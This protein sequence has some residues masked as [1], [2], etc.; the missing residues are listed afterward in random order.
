VAR[1]RGRRAHARTGGAND[2]GRGRR[3]HRVA[4]A[5]D[6]P[7][8]SDAI[9]KNWRRS[10][11]PRPRLTRGRS[12]SGGGAGERVKLLRA[13]AFLSH[14]LQRVTPR[15]GADEAEYRSRTQR[16][17]P[18]RRS[19][20]RKSG[21]TIASCSISF[22]LSVII[23]LRCRP[24]DLNLIDQ[25]RA[26]NPELLRRPRAFATVEP[27]RLLDVHPFTSAAPV[28]YGARRPLRRPGPPA[29]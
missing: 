20:C 23:H 27:E 17:L 29:P 11:A 7:G 6:W 13:L 19:H 9:G 2:G 14:V 21:N 15:E 5:G 8:A 16:C 3:A 18:R 28:A 1:A 24:V 22:G 25:R 4:A 10:W 12:G 26:R